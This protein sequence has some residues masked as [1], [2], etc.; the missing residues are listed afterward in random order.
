MARN[1]H[2]THAGIIA[3][4]LTQ[5]YTR[6]LRRVMRHHQMSDE[7]TMLMLRMGGAFDDLP[8]S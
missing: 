7:L 4:D 2:N 3:P 8:Q 5:Q 6:Y 1:G